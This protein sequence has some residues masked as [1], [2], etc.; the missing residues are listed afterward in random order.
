MPQASKPDTRRVQTMSP[1]PPAPIAIRTYPA[2]SVNLCFSPCRTRPSRPLPPD[3]DPDSHPPML[4]GPSKAHSPTPAHIPDPHPPMPP[5]APPR[6]AVPASCATRPLYNT[7]PRPRPHPILQTYR[8]RH[9][10][11]PAQLYQPP[12]LP[13]PCTTHSPAPAPIPNCKL[14]DAATRSSPLSCTSLLCY[15]APVQ[16]TPPPPPLSPTAN[17]LMPPPAPP[18]SAVPASC[19]GCAAWRP[20]APAAWPPAAGTSPCSQS[21]TRGPGA[22]TACAGGGRGHKGGKER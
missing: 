15:P 16:H 11:L 17:L 20:P 22:G 18:R 12:V 21:G 7:L 8:C 9:P 14:T 6:S 19:A 13:G 1:C 5:P 3:P 10:L 4:P 2:A